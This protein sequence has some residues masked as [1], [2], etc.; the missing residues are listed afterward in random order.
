VELSK[1]FLYEIEVAASHQR[2]GIAR[3]LIKELEHICKDGAFK[4]MFVFTNESNFPAME[5]YAA[6]GAKR[7]N[8]DD[9]MFVYNC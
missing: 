7:E 3:A 2:R 4:S 5:L 1:M 9:V 6:T 8:T